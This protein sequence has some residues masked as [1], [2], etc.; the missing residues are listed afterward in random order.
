MR[1]EG[2]GQYRYNGEVETHW[3]NIRVILG[4]YGDNGKENGNPLGNTGLYR[5]NGN[6][7]ETDKVYW[8]P[9]GFSLGVV[10]GAF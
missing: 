1:I 2:L 8:V 4:F 3:G 7:S 10:L 9:S 6:Q 5:D